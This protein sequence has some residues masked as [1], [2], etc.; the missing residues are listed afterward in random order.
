L[1]GWVASPIAVEVGMGIFA[2]LTR[3]VTGVVLIACSLGA[4]IVLIHGLLLSRSFE[5]INKWIVPTAFI[6]Y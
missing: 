3:A 1:S 6:G 4:G 5:V 2:V